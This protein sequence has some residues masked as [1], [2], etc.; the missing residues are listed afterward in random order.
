L[1]VDWKKKKEPAVKAEATKS[2]YLN[3]LEKEQ[4]IGEDFNQLSIIIDN[5]RNGYDL[6]DA[7]RKTV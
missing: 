5:T 3:Q 4:R 7:A 1:K 6:P 2:G